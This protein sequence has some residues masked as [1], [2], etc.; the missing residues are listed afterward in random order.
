[1]IFIIFFFF[2]F[3]INMTRLQIT[4]EIDFW[5]SGKAFPGLPEK[6]CPSSEWGDP[7]RLGSQTD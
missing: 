7:N 1:M 6:T 5:V 3:T 2:F 4:Q